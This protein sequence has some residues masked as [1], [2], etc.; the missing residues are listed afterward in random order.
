M[1][2]VLMTL[3]LGGALFAFVT[4]L[5]PRP[6]Q[7]APADG[8]SLLQTL[9]EWQYPDSKLR[10]GATM[11]DGGNPHV[12]SIKCEAVL[13]SPD[14]IEKVIAYYAEKF[15]AVEPGAPRPAKAEVKKGEAKSVSVQ[16]DSE[17]RPVVLRVFVV[18]KVDTSTT[19]VISRAEGEP[20]THIAW[21][22]YIRLAER[23]AK[24]A[25]DRM[26]FSLGIYSGRENPTPEEIEA[27]TTG[28][29]ISV[30]NAKGDRGIPEFRV[31]AGVSSGGVASEFE[32]RTGQTVIN[33]QPHTCRIGKEGDY[34]WPLAKAYAEMAL[35]VEADGYQPQVDHGSQEGQGRTAYRR[36]CSPRTKAWPGAC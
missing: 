7:A 19:L 27:R 4:T 29:R 35:R 18:N 3:A 24:A 30:L 21:S 33:W 1:R 31:I 17:G 15:G 11:S 34:V 14:P 32:K 36:S 26:Q 22:H 5:A 8:I 23:Q 20:E 25:D 10:G 28:I 12:P 9:G 13:T 16:D 2:S 6:A